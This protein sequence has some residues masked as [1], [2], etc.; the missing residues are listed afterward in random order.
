NAA[1]MDMDV[2]S[3]IIIVGA[4]ISGVGMGIELKKYHLHSF[5]IL[6]SSGSLGGTW[7]D[8]TY[9]GVAVDIPSLSYSF[10]F[11]PNPNWSRLFAPG[12]EIL[13][14]LKH[15]AEKYGILQHIRYNSN[16]KKIVFDGRRHIWDVY[17]DNGEL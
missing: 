17:L 5:T 1:D 4:G 15:C 12:Q 7:R 3:E 14:Y 13:Q 10:S 9:P 11:E 16:V 2:D 6:E 8:N